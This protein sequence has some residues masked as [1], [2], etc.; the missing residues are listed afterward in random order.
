MTL[1]IS[2]KKDINLIVTKA[3]AGEEKKQHSKT[4]IGV[5]GWCRP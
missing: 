1:K 4:V 5:G 2:Q 3:L